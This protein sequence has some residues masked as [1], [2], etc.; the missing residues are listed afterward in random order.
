MHMCPC[1]FPRRA[2]RALKQKVMSTVSNDSTFY[3]SAQE[4]CVLSLLNVS[5][6]TI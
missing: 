3:A 4:E 1:G 2:G 6:E 5:D